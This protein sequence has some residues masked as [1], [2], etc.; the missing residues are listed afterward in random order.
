KLG[1][2]SDRWVRLEPE[3]WRAESQALAVDY[4]YTPAVL[5]HV[6][7]MQS[8]GRENVALLRLPPEYM[9]RA[10]EVGRVRVYQA[11]LRL[12]RIWREGL[13]AR[14]EQPSP[15]KPAPK[16]PAPKRPAV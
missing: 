10:G 16:K 6:R 2:R 12:A 15:K 11:G 1:K 14:P 9:R 5:A 13:N 4:V 7:A 8:A 3:A